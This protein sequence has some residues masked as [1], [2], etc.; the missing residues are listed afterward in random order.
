MKNLLDI[1]LE[2]PESDLPH[3]AKRWDPEGFRER[4][5]RRKREA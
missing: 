5:E 2:T 1:P 4:M 3:Y